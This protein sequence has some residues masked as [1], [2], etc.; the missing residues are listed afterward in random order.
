MQ[1]M[2]LRTGFR[3]YKGQQIPQLAKVFTIQSGQECRLISIFKDGYEYKAS[4]YVFNTNEIKI[5]DYGKIEK[6]L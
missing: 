4:I 5:V 6:Y 2:P 1:T 3:E